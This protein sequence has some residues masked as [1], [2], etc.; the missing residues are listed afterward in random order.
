MMQLMLLG[1]G[2]QASEAQS[3]TYMDFHSA[4]NFI[5]KAE[6]EEET[7][8]VVQPPTGTTQKWGLKRAE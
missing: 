4:K 6:E 8:D 2:Y 7:D 5:V 3:I 1:N